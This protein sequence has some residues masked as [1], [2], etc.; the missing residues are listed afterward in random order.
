MASGSSRV[1]NEFS[2]YHFKQRFGTALWQRYGFEHVLRGD[3]DTL[4]VARYILENPVRARIVASVED[5]PF[6][7]STVYS[8]G[9]SSRRFRRCRRRGNR[10]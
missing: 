10:S 7:G 1:Q 3:E 2:G 4:F 5:Y 8:V 6:L 9:T